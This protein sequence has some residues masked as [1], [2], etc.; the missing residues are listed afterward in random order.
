[1]K[2]VFEKNA[3]AVG[4]QE[5]INDPRPEKLIEKGITTHDTL[6]W[7]ERRPLPPPHPRPSPDD[8]Q[9][10]RN[11]AQHAEVEHAR[12]IADKRAAFIAKAEKTREDF[13]T[14]RDYRYPPGRHER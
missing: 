12:E 1:M 3:D 9:G 11:A 2:D 13:H 6:D 5:E 8:P 7:E 10:W 14:A 4:K